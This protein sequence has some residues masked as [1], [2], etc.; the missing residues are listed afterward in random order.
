MGVG[1]PAL[2]H[3]GVRATVENAG[4]TSIRSAPFP[5]VIRSWPFPPYSWSL[6][7]P[8]NARIFNPRRERDGPPKGAA[9][10][11]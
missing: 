4:A 1:H 11:R 8:P 3:V 2:A 5:P 9:P 7:R 6:P 10:W